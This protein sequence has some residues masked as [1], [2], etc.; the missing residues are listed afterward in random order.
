MDLSGIIFDWVLD[1]NVRD[2]EIYQ[3]AKMPPLGHKL[4]VPYLLFDDV[5]EIKKL[6][7]KNAEEVAIFMK[8]I[9]AKRQENLDKQI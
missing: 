5:K 1:V 8:Y 4:I 2:V 7:G 3:N 6:K 9:N